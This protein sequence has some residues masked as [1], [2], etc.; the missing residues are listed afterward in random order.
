LTRAGSAIAAIIIAAAAKVGRIGRRVGFAR[1]VGV[2]DYFRFLGF[3][4]VFVALLAG[5][6]VG[7]FTFAAG[8]RGDAVRAGT[9]LRTSGGS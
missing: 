6:R 3:A 8:R 9:G 1:G 5:L 2:C 7:L 4:A